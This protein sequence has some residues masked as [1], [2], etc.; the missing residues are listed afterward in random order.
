MVLPLLLEI[1]SHQE[2][3]AETLILVGRFLIIFLAARSLAELMVRLQLPS[4]LGELVAGVLIG[5][6]GLHL[7]LPPES[8]AQLAAWP[9]QLV[10]QLAAVSTERVREIYMSSFGSLQQLSTLGL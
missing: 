9:V 4:I 5:V 8:G 10:S 3:V 7:L 1:G 2:D 6:S